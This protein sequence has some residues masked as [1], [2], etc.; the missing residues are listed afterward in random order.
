MGGG[1]YLGVWVLHPGRVGGRRLVGVGLVVVQ[2]EGLLTAAVVDA[3]GGTLHHGEAQLHVDLRSSSPLDEAAAQPMAGGAV[4]LTDLI[5]PHAVVLL[6]QTTYFL[7]LRAE[8]KALSK[9]L[10]MTPDPENFFN[11]PVKASTKVFKKGIPLKVL[12]IIIML[13]F[14][15]GPLLHCTCQRPWGH[16]RPAVDLRFSPH[17]NVVC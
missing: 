17:L 1:A 4:S 2:V 6:I 10:K 11:S 16:I 9:V 15:V 7:P 12:F 5:G 13:R 3:P 8:N 14:V